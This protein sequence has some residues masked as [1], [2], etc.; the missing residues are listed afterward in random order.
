MTNTFWSRFLD[1]LRGGQ[2]ENETES[3]AE[4]WGEFGSSGMPST[5]NSLPFAEMAE[6]ARRPEEA[7]PQGLPSAGIS[8]RPL[9]YSPVPITR[10]YSATGEIYE[11]R[12]AGRAL[13]A[14]FDARENSTI[15]WRTPDD[16]VV[17]RF[18]ELL[19]PK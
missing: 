5:G 2:R 19:E 11:L 16:D 7:W 14:E 3:P 17:Q 18:R 4:P 6:V 10:R 1:G 15:A 8:I 13:R 9:E 12:E